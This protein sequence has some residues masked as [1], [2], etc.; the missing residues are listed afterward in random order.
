MKQTYAA[1]LMSV[2]YNLRY[3]GMKRNYENVDIFTL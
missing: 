3:N 2:S 1:H